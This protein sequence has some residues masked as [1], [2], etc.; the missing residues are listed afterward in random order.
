MKILTLQITAGNFE[1]ILKGEQK[2]ETRL[3]DSL[4]LMKR[5]YELN[6]DNGGWD[7][8]KYDALK[9]INGR[10]NNAPELVVKV[11]DYLIEFFE[12][13]NGDELIFTDVKTGEEMPFTRVCYR[14]GEVIEYKNAEDFFSADRKPLKVNFMS[15][16][17][18]EEKSQ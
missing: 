11:T 15:L 18:F 12:D 10:K 7:L 1:A 4:T 8:K 9:L 16:K 5:H 17:E 6:Q 14:L 3:C 13:E 2:V